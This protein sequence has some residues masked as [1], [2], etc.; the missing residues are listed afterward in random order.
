MIEKFITKGG[1]IYIPP[2]LVKQAESIG[3]LQFFKAARPS[4]IKRMGNT[5]CLKAHDSL[6]MSQNG[7]WNWFSQGIGGGNAI[8]YLVKVEEMPFQE[9]VI[10]VLKNVFGDIDSNTFLNDSNTFLRDSSAILCDSN[11]FS[12]NSNASNNINIFLDESDT[13]KDFQIPE[14]DNDNQLISGY[15]MGK[16]GID[17][18]VILHFIKEGSLY[19]EKYHKSVCFLGFDKEGIPRI[20]NLRG[21]YRKFQSTTKGSDRN[22]GFTLNGIKDS[23]HIFEAPIDLMSYAT[24]I[25]RQGYDFRHFNMLSLSGIS[26]PAKAIANSKK[27]GCLERYL[28]D[29]QNIKTIYVHFD[30][31]EA[32][33]NAAK[34]VKYLY[35]SDYEIHIE[36]PPEGYKDIND[37][38]S[39]QKSIISNNKNGRDL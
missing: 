38:I 30:N 2:K 4:E 8:S 13:H 18:E 33:I 1:K 26:A 32:G 24:I 39:F 16:R 28:T 14:K 6:M 9:A 21:I 36:H 29:H 23:L 22:Y 11:A 20:A 5:Y 17:P 31:D 27:P 10:E 37:L 19:Q 15:L 3:L 12:N 25:N 7:K 35:E 34:A